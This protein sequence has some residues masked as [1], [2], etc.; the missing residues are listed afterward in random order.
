MAQEKWLVDGPKSIDVEGVRAL[1]VGLVGGSVDIVA[2]DE[3]GVRIEVHG[4]T[5]KPLRI[6]LDGD[7]LEVDHPQLGWEN[8][9]DLFRSFTGKDRAELSIAVPRDV[10]LKLGVVSATA[11]VSGLRGDVAASTVSGDLVIDGVVGDLKLNA[12]SGE[13]AVRGHSGRVGVNTVSGDVAVSGEVR[14]FSSDG[15]SGDVLLDLDGTPDTVRINTVSGDVSARLAHGV[16]VSFTINTVGGKLQL[17]ELAV[18]GVRGRYTHRIGEL[19][20][21]WLDFTANTVSGDVSVLH[22]ALA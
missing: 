1:K 3:P 14:E 2:R 5:G 15:V 18:R 7:R 21:R 10:A 20:G 12:V 4:V 6:T 8:W 22:G 11:L 19:D 17:D 9:T 13:L 16:P